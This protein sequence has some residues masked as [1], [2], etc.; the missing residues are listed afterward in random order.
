[1]NNTIIGNEKNIL[2]YSDEEGNTKVE[3]LLENEDVWLNTEAI[4]S[5]FNVDRSGIVRH[6]NN[7]YKDDELNENITCAKIAHM[8]NDGKQ[9]Y[10]TKYYN[11]DMIISIGFRVNSKKAIKFRTWANKIIK[12]YMVQGFAL[13]DDRFM[14]ARKTDQEYFKR[15]LEKIKLIR[16]S[17]RMFYQKITDI[18]AEC[19]I[20]Y[21]K[22]SDTA[23]TFYKTIQNKFHYAI[24]GKTAAEIIYNRADSKK[25]NMGLATWENSPNGKILKTD[26]IIAKNYLDEKEIKNLNNL[27]NLFLDIAENN[28]ERNIVMCMND[29]KNEVENAIKV[30]HYGVLNDKGKISH[31][32]AQDKAFL[33]YE[34]YKVIQDKSFVSDFDKLLIEAKNIENKDN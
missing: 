21:D 1:M 2:F 27:V 14:K 3:V 5:L 22:N 18:F 12:D 33:E 8:G 19:S 24:T 4:S 20:D 31:Q 16:T 23:L 17:E 6:I 28:A 34:K 11:L 29:W 10:N 30:F 7:I 13:N 15:L 25:E 32:M 26:V 9:V